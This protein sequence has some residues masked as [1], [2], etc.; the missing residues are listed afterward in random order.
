M[1][2]FVKVG[3]LTKV[4]KTVK[5]LLNAVEEAVE[6]IICRKDLPPN[7]RWREEGYPYENCWG[8]D[9]LMSEAA[10]AGKDSLLYREARRIYWEAYWRL[11]G[12][13]KRG[14][15]FFETY[16]KEHGVLKPLRDRERWVL[17]N[18]VAS[19]I[20][21]GVVPPEAL[22]YTYRIYRELF[23]PLTARS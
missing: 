20:A 23:G 12:R 10:K 4:A 1:L 15:P 5:R 21:Y 14:R 3:K 7:P 13:Y 6:V 18:I 9:E 22:E 11:L 2:R 17:Y 8:I 19:A 16:I